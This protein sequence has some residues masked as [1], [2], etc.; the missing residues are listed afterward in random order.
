MMSNEEYMLQRISEAT[1]IGVV[2]VKLIG[3]GILTVIM[4]AIAVAGQ[5]NGWW[6][7]H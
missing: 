4:V 3:Y 5:E 2:A 6:G 7:N 1:G